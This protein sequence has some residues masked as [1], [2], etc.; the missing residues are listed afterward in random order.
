MLQFWELCIEE[1]HELYSASHVYFLKKSSRI[2]A[3]CNRNSEEYEY[4]N[5]YVRRMFKVF[6]FML[7]SPAQQLLDTLNCEQRFLFRSKAGFRTGDFL[8][9]YVPVNSVAVF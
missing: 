5:V 4:T 2:S 8:V 3:T 1:R 9:I 6:K 7:H